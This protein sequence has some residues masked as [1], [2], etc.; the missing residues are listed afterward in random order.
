MEPLINIHKI[1][2]SL[3]RDDYN[4]EDK[5]SNFPE[6]D[7]VPLESEDVATFDGIPYIDDE[8]NDAELSEM[9]KDPEPDSDMPPPPAWT[10]CSPADIHFNRDPT[11]YIY[12]NASVL[13]NNVFHSQSYQQ[14]YM[15]VNVIK[16]I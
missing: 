11:V 2:T 16:Q 1:F 12:I 10:R 7:Y 3:F 6:E 14:S 4:Y 5:T 9:M 15:L 8:T 13:F